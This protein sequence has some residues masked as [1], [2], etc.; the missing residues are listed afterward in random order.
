MFEQ[1]IKRENTIFEV[2]QEFVNAQLPFVLVGGYAIS[3]YKHRFSVDADLVL[4]KEDKTKFEEILK[5][6]KFAKTI[7]KDLDHVYAPE[8]IRYESKE[9]LPVSIDLLIGGVGSR[10]TNASFSV[11]EISNYSK[12]RKIIGT[13]K[14]ITVLVPDREVLIALKLHS[15]RLTDFRDI[16]ALS[17]NLELGVIKKLIWRGKRQVVKSNIKKLISLAEKKEFIDSFKGVFIEKRYDVD[18]L[19]VKRLRL[20]L[21]EDK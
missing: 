8:F 18:I 10:D 1:F 16:V 12:K 15:G 3:A 9:K 13:E 17:K 7:V 20:L 14:E 2:L 21:D 11:E 5:K 6:K 4:R 19:E